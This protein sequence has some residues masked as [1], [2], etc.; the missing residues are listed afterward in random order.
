M[1]EPR[2]WGNCTI[3][4]CLAT[5]GDGFIGSP[6]WCH[7]RDAYGRPASAGC[8][9]A[10][11]AAADAKSRRLGGISS[12]EVSMSSFR[13]SSSS[14]IFAF[15]GSNP[16]A[17][18]VPAGAKVEIETQDCFAN[19]LQTAEDT[20]ESVDWNQIN[21]A[22][23]PIFIEG[24][25]PGDSLKI[26][27]EAIRPGPQGVMVAGKDLGMF[28][29]RLTGL[30]SKLVP[31]REGM[32][33]FD[34][35]LLLPLNP[36]LGVI[37]VAPSEG[38]VNCGTPGPHGGNMDN[39]MVTVGATLYLPV[40]VE[41]ALFALGDMH[42]AMGDGEIGVSGVEVAGTVL[43]QLEVM[44]GLTLRN[45]LLENKDWISTIASAPTLDEAVQQATED[46]G[47][48]LTERTGRPLAEMAMLMSAV[49]RAQICQVVDPLKT[50]RF[51]M[52][53]WVV[54]RLGIAL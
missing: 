48:L 35:E 52:P 43:V 19:Q 45:P 28:G 34:P 17:L 49:G 30:T 7:N 47:S 20:L 50:A 27:I 13:L 16:P 21:P 10:S 54:Q 32:A 2:F 25:K 11:E 18:T 26:I 31:I 41:G 4:R 44:K 14:R 42:A 51:L 5:A 6:I 12:S 3:V 36:M 33:V 29:P 40:F 39:T 8:D 53:K 23:G 9:C 37:G 46:M 38:S 15:S 1:P 24:A 22:T